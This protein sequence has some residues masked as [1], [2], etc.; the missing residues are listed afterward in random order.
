VWDTPVYPVIPLPDCELSLTIR[1]AVGR[2]QAW[3]MT[4]M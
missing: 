1:D 4:A 3:P 2:S